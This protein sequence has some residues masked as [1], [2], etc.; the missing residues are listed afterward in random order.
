M[1]ALGVELIYLAN[2][3]GSIE[4]DNGRGNYVRLL[5]ERIGPNALDQALDATTRRYRDKAS[6]FLARSSDL[7]PGSRSAAYADMLAYIID[8]NL[9]STAFLAHPAAFG[10]YSPTVRECLER[11]LESS[12]LTAMSLRP[13]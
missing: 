3:I 13:S 1:K 11:M 8:G 5:A 6:E 12:L 9:R 10:R 4:R 7:A 2:D